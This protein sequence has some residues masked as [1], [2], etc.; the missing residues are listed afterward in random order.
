MKIYEDVVVKKVGA[1]VCDIYPDIDPHFNP[2]SDKLTDNACSTLTFTFGYGS[3][4]DGMV[5]ELDLSE[6]AS[7]E[8]FEM[9]R[10]KYGADKIDARLKDYMM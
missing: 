3:S 4:M 2:L 6:K 10:N 8:I 7:K 1:V 9:L 5:L